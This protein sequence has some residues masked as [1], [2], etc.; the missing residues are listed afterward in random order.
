MGQDT[1]F[2][3]TS[4]PSPR[5]VDAEEGHG[6]AIQRTNERRGSD[7]WIEGSSQEKTPDIREISVDPLT[8]IDSPIVKEPIRTP[9]EDRVP[10]TSSPK[11]PAT[12]PRRKPRLAAIVPD[13]APSEQPSGLA[14]P[15]IVPP[16]VDTI[17]ETVQD[18]SPRSKL[19]PSSLLRELVT[20]ARSSFSGRGSFSAPRGSISEAPSNFPKMMQLPSDYEPKELEENKRDDKT[21]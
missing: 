1:F 5:P 9:E 4:Q 10:S 16:V 3:T 12:K 19:R 17:D 20:S 2:S 18:D 21:P 8:V 13:P 14:P 11:P 15:S 6:K 7:V